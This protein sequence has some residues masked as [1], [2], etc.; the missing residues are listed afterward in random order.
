MKHPGHCSSDGVVV[1]VDRFWVVRP[2]SRVER[3]SGGQEGLDGFVSEDEQR[4]HCSEPGWEWLVSAGVADP[5][6]DLFAAKLLEIISG[7][8]GAIL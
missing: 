8:S 3:S 4:R 2:A 1:G 7:V 5:A 6:N